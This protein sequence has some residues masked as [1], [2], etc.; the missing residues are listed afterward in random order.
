VVAETPL[1]VDVGEDR[2][3]VRVGEE[4]GGRPLQR[5]GRAPQQPCDGGNCAAAFAELPTQESA[6]AE[7]LGEQT[8][9]NRWSRVRN[10]G[11]NRP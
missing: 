10:D 5:G 9:G 4:S 1:A 7:P 3:P 11:P 2:E 8:W 6:G